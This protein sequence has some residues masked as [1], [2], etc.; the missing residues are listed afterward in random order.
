MK[1]SEYCRY[2]A[3][4]LAELVRKGEVTQSEL[5]ALARAAHDAT[6]ADINAVCEFYD[7]AEEREAHTGPLGGVPIL[8]KD[9]GATEK[10]RKTEYGSRLFKGHVA[11]EDSYYTTRCK[12][13][14][15]NFVGRSTC[16]EIAVAGMTETALNGIT[17]NPWNRE[18]TAGGSSGGAGAAVAAGVVPIAH[19]SDGGGSIRIPAAWC[20]AVGLNPTRGRISGGPRNQD[21]LLGLAR[22]FVICRTVRDMATALDALSGPEPG[23]PFVIPRPDRPFADE[24]H[25]STRT[26]RI[27]VVREAWGKVG[28]QP[29]ILAEVDRVA[30]TLEQMGHQVSEFGC[31]I[32]PIDI[33]V[34]VMG[35]FVLPLASMREV[36][37][38]L[39]RDISADYFE[40]VTLKLID[41]AEAMTPAEIMG[42]F[43]TF[44]RVRCDVAEASAPYDMLLTPCLPIVAPEHGAF[45]TN[46]PALSAAEFM[47]SDSSI[48]TYMG[49]FNVTG[50][51]SV[52]LPTGHSTDGLPIGI[53]LVAPFAQEALLVRVARDIE[54][55]LPWLHKTPPVFA[56]GN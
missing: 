7:D 11:T 1:L 31:P 28:L 2:D 9:I 39:G 44:K 17:R 34:G 42:I 5:A 19:A 23:D 37:R 8:R 14:G 35:G 24:W 40:P 33:E 38:E 22:E 54:E 15:L 16:S 12:A 49:T 27:G 3:T 56:G 48:F 41:R 25:Q 36:A 10:G 13:A 46:N 45:S 51:P 29:E 53:Q 55:A 20:G 18:R 21:A 43:E 26:L 30:A 32:N 50:Q 47:A 6:H 4:G 52:S